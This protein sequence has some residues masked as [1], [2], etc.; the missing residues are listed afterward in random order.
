[1]ARA[2]ERSGREIPRAQETPALGIT[3]RVGGLQAHGLDKEQGVKI[4][5]RQFPECVSR[6]ALPFCCV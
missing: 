3:G 2:W 1:M 6:G 5:E 4:L